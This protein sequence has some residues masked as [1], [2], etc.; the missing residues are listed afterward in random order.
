MKEHVPDHGPF[1]QRATSRL[2]KTCEEPGCGEL[3][4]SFIVYRTERE[5]V[6][7]NTHLLLPAV[8]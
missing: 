2:G 6:E 3:R 7:K 5:S 8:N 4:L 1:W